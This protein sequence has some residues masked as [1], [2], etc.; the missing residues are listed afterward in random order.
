MLWLITSGRYKQTTCPKIL[1]IF[2]ESCT[3]LHLHSGHLF[4][5]V[6]LVVYD[7][8]LSDRLQTYVGVT[9]AAET[10]YYLMVAC[11]ICMA[12]WNVTRDS[13]IQASWDCSGKV[14]YERWILSL[15]FTSIQHQ[16]ANSPY[17][18]S[19]LRRVFTESIY[20][21][22][23]IVRTNHEFWCRSA[24][25]SRTK[26]VKCSSSLQKWLQIRPSPSSP[27]PWGL[28]PPCLHLCLLEL[29]NLL[30]YIIENNIRCAHF[31]KV[32]VNANAYLQNSFSVRKLHFRE[33]F[34]NPTEVFFKYQEFRGYGILILSRT[35][36]FFFGNEV[37]DCSLVVIEFVAIVFGSCGLDSFSS[38]VTVEY[39]SS[40]T[41]LQN[42]AFVR[43]TGPGNS[44]YNENQ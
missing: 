44:I 23:Q 40:L 38:V 6:K 20:S 4:K 37:C 14:F 5:N 26:T 41:D 9:R 19:N 2:W 13:L 10:N 36:F 22:I 16:S 29:T 35:F 43:N 25:G 28:S 31:K 34:K 33:G 42:P 30:L 7:Q 24:S 1:T 21:V 3:Y 39:M 18:R 12:R 8:F 15:T 11:M 32:K 17:P 27:V